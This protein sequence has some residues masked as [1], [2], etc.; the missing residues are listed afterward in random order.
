MKKW[1]HFGEFTNLSLVKNLFWWSFAVWCVGSIG[2]LLNWINGVFMVGKLTDDIHWFLLL[3][4]IDYYVPSFLMLV[5]SIV[6]L[7]LGCEVIYKIINHTS[8]Q[9]K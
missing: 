8:P 5:F 2:M 6:L 4:Q 3:Q 1:F 7:R 9:N